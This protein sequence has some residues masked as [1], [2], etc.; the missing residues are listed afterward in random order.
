MELLILFLVVSFLL[1]LFGVWGLELLSK[2]A[3]FFVLFFLL[4]LLLL[5]PVYNALKEGGLGQY[6]SSL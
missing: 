3:G 5:K 2:L 6:L 1:V 4:Y